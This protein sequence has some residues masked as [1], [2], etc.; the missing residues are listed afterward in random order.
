MARTQ[1]R[2]GPGPDDSRARRATAALPLVSPSL[3]IAGVGPG[4]GTAVAARFAEGGWDLGLIARDQDSL[5]TAEGELGGHD[6]TV[7]GALADVTDAPALDEAFDRLASELGTPLVMIYNASVYQP[8]G[9][10]ELSPEGLHLA[11]QVHVEGAFNAARSAVRRM[12]PSRHGVLVFTINCL[13]L[14]PEAV[15][16]ALSIG[17]GAQHNLALSLESELVETGIRVAVVTITAPIRP[18]T[19]F[20]PRR[21]AGLYWTVANQPPERFERDHTFA[22]AR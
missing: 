21:I 17:K 3:L 22:G 19:A 18:G 12:R 10:L 4:L 11:F 6:V 7:R 5:D 20:D 14:H 8:E 9:V 13:A 16:A 15:S 2:P 1:R